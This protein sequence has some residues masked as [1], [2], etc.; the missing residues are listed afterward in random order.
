MECFSVSEVLSALVQTLP[1]KGVLE[2][3]T[4]EP[5]VV[6]LVWRKHR[7]RVSIADGVVSEIVGGRTHR[8]T[9][10]VLLEHALRRELAA[11]EGQ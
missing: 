5:Q 1:T 3:L 8:T 4:I 2:D 10:A 6:R 9:I 11:D 7:F